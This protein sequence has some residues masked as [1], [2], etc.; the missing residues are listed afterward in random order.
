MLFNSYV[1][2]FAFLPIALA[3]F[4]FAGRLGRGPAAGWLGTVSLIFY[5]WWQPLFLP[6]LVVSILVNYGFALVIERTA[7]RPRLASPLLAAAIAGNLTALF[8]CKYLAALVAGLHAAGIAPWTIDPIALPLGI[9]FFTFTQIGYLVDVR[10]DTAKERGFVD[11]VLFVT[12]FP[13]LIAGPILH[14]REI[15]PQFASRATFRPDARNLAI[16]ATIF[17]IGLCKKTVLADPTGVV[18]GAGFAHPGDQPLLAAWH[19]ALSY[20]L[21]LYFDFSGYSDMAIGLARLFNITFPLNF[22]SPYKAA[23][24]IE[25]WQR[26]HM[27]LTRYLTLYL[28][29][30]L[31]LAITRRLAARGLAGRRAQTTVRG[32][33][34]MVAIP[35]LTTMALAGVWHGAGLQFIVFG[36]LHGIYLTV[37]HAWRT[38]RPRP[39]QAPPDSLAAHAGK[40][41]LTYLCVLVG[42]VFFRAS[43]VAAGLQLLGGMLG[44][45]G[46]GTAPS[47]GDLVWI[48]L[49]YGIVWGCPNTQQIM[50]DAAPAL[51]RIRAAAHGPRWHTSLGWALA[52]GVATLIGIVGI[53]DKSEFLYFQF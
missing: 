10:Q 30:P 50:V 31:A 12:F 16:G 42:S 34:W 26:W 47:A 46:F 40:V 25:Y 7:S 38:W 5:G 27:T 44:T 29:N 36:C 37:A 52:A 33:T 43:S 20:S 51:G 41:L 35:T 9:S 8:Y 24:V 18:V 21:Q 13:H 17:A 4:F 1:F 22:D 3:G 39:K 2:L 19:V 11:Y 23:S 32:F 53:G 6:V 14:H 48:A 28:Y 15:M 45:H 49:L